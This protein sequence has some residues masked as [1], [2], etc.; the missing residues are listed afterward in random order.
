ME[1]IGFIG[2]GHMGRPIAAGL[3][4]AGYEVL[5]YDVYPKALESVKGLKTEILDDIASHA[6]VI[7]TMLP[8]AHELLSIYE[9]GTRFFQEIRPDALLIDCSTIGPIASKQWHQLPFA[10][11]DAPVSGGIIAAQNNQL[12]YM[13]GGHPEDVLKAQTILQKIAKQIIVTG[14]PGTGQ[15]AKICNNLILGNTMIAVSE[16]FL[17]GEK[18]GL[19]P[20][21]LHEVL[22]LSS[23]HSWVTE[24]YLPVPDIIDNVPANHQYHAGF[25][26]KMMLKDLKLALNASD[27]ENLHL[28]L[29]EKA[30]ALYEMLCQ[31][32]LNHL[33]FSSIYEF[34]KNK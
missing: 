29:T 6:E 33:D 31:T 14:G 25:S 3:A 21:K 30:T 32:E 5:A 28:S 23:G 10:T 17:L 24:K 1:K 13:M 20:K 2:V 12:T 22:E 7:I 4:Q 11:V 18:L 27:A 26:N 9:P 19:D 34:I 15:M 16:G 8:S